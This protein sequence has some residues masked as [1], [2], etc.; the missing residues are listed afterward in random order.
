VT[1][2][3]TIFFADL[4][5]VIG[6]E[7][8]GTRPVIVISDETYNTVMPVVTILP[9]TSLKQGRRVYP[10]EAL[11]PAG[12]GSI[13]RDSIALVHQIRTISKERLGEEIGMI[14]EPSVQD[15]INDAIRVHL[16]L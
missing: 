2:K 9:L 15:S 3:W 13:P 11:L 5:P 14:T 6:S 1:F 16:N 4:N 12:T 7:Q 10:N 8:A